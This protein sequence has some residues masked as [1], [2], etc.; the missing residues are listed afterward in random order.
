MQRNAKAV[1]GVLAA[2]LGSA[3]FTDAGYAQPAPSPPFAK[4]ALDAHGNPVVP[5]S[6]MPGDIVK[7][8]L[9]VPNNTVG[10]LQVTDTLIDQTYL[11]GSL[12]VPPGWSYVSTL[13]TSSSSVPYG[14]GNHEVYSTTGAG[15]AKS[16]IINIPVANQSVTSVLGG[17]GFTPIPIPAVGHDYGIFHHKPDNIGPNGIMCWEFLTLAKCSTS[18]WPQTIGA[19]LMTPTLLRHFIDG[20]RIYFPS[21]LMTGSG[22]TITPGVGCWDAAADTSCAFIPLPGGPVWSSLLPSGFPSGLDPIFAGVAADPAGGRLF[23][24]AVNSAS[25]PTTGQV[26][27]V[28]LL[29]AACPWTSSVVL[30]ANLNTSIADLMI[31]PVSSGVTPRLYVTHS[32]LVSCINIATGAACWKDKV[33]GLN[34][35]ILSPFLDPTATTML[36]VCLLPRGATVPPPP[37]CFDPS[38]GA[39]VTVNPAFATL[40]TSLVNLN[41]FSAFLIP[42]TTN[43]LYTNGYSSTTGSPLCFDF[44]RNSGAGGSCQNFTPGWSATSFMDYGY[45]VDPAVPGCVLGLGDDGQLWR[46]TRDGGFNQKGCTQ[47]IVQTLDFNSF[48]CGTPPSNATWQDITIISGQLNG[49]TITLTDNAGHGPTNIPITASTTYAIPA[50]FGSPLTVQIVPPTGMTN[51]AQVKV[52]F[53]AK[54]PAEICYKAVVAGCGPIS[55]SAAISGSLAGGPVPIPF[56]GTANV[57]LGNA[58]GPTCSPGLLKICKVAGPG[59]A[60]GTPFIFS[61]GSATFSVPAGPPPGG[62]CVSG[63]QLP[64]G[65][66]VT[67]SETIPRGDTVS[68][69]SVAPA[70][71]V[72]G[73]PNLAGG[74]VDVTMGSGVTEVTF[75]DKRTGFVEI[76]KS[77]DVLGSFTFTVT[78]GNVGPFT[79]PAGAC[80]APIEVVPGQITIT[81]TTPGVVIA[82]CSTFPA[83]QQVSCNSPNSVVTVAPGDI[84]A[85]TVAYIT[86]R[87]SRSGATETDESGR[88][89]PR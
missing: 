74:S 34:G 23:L 73:A 39:N 55:N 80:T 78:P 52:T 81:E 3:A 17:D 67:V 60:V 49:G 44:A 62:T 38:N 65:S 15:P 2:V 86:N 21:A 42:G 83:G 27:C 76:C 19:G 11:S 33:S 13:G 53:T 31:E 36:Q 45:A 22:A 40:M 9:S 10:P 35:L 20:T 50:G 84:S 71:Q 48:F 30:T 1:A 56:T 58:T 26:Y 5:G 70:G 41:F 72:I 66:P 7:Y 12:Q 14:L 63:P 85:E 87:R 25:A 82:G 47:K 8:V 24:Y 79:V 51:P 4:Q 69:I 77:G 37:V 16:F 88:A 61:A 59:I 89:A 6:L 29:P 46:F 68:S 43:M 54:T 57:N 75:T 28:E 32:G 18:T 64:V